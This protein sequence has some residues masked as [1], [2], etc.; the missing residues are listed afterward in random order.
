VFC[1]RCGQEIDD[2]SEICPQCGRKTT[3]SLPLSSSVTT[4]QSSASAVPNLMP[5]AMP[6]GKRK[7][8]GGWLMFFCILLIVVDPLFV[9]IIA[10]SAEPGPDYASYIVWAGLGITVG[11]M[12]WNLYRHSFV[13]LWIYFGVTAL[14]LAMRIAD[15]AF[16]ESNQNSHEITLV[17][18]SAIYSIAWF[19]YFKRSDRVKTTFGRNL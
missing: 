16:V 9:M 11:I 12:I 14:L 4:Q 2:A 18:R 5:P 19:L 13:W 15:F 1:A 10:W 7:E 8:I 3:L 17:F 6:L